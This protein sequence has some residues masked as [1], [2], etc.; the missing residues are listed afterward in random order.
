M[1]ADQGG[2][3]IMFAP[4]PKP[5][6]TDFLSAYGLDESDERFVDAKYELVTK[7]RNLR[8]EFNVSGAKKVRFILRANHELPPYEAAVLKLLL[9]A[10][11]VEFNVDV[12]KG[13]PSVGTQ[14]G[15][16]FLPLEGLVDVAAEKARLNK[17]LEKIDAE[18]V[19]V[20]EKLNNPNFT[21]KVPPAVLEEHQKRLDEWQAKRESILRNLRLLDGE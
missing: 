4:W 5:L 3:T 15:D 19:K 20:Q 11:S 17:E 6:G 10:G 13:T 14:L 21:Q 9:N 18:I 8:R 12:K 16:L 2:I 7:A 1:P